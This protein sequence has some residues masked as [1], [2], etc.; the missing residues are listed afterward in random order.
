MR[1]L[2]NSI[3][4]LEHNK[5]KITKEYTGQ[6]QPQLRKIVETQLNIQLRKHIKKATLFIEV[7][8]E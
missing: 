7:E 5:T 2:N 6:K 4:E 1:R 8:Y 3:I